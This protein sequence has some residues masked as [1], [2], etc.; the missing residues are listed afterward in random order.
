M[1]AK[2]EALASVKSITEALL[3]TIR[4]KGVDAAVEQYRELRSTESAAYDFSEEKLNSLGY[5]LMAMKR[6]KDAI[7]I[8][9]LN[10]EA[11]PQSANVH[12]SLGEAYMNDGDNEHAIE[13]YE[14]LLQLDPMSGN[15]I[16]KL[17][18]LKVH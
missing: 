10:M 16:V 2:V 11:Y 8:L 12:D 9:K 1:L 4:E 17:K 3:E 7:K 14:K 13:H 15:A 18:Q 5:Q 6:T